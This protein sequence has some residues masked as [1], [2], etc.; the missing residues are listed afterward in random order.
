MTLSRFKTSGKWWFWISLT[1][2]VV[3][4]FL[5]IWGV[6]GDTMMPAAIWIL[7]FTHLDHFIETLMGI[8]MFCLFFGV[9]AVSIG[10][11]LQCIAVMIRDT[12]KWRRDHAA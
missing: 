9:P 12:V 5:P 11:I 2:F 6:K 7:L 4:W 8:C 10:W 3:P 1:L